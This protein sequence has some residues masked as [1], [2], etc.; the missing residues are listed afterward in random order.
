MK[1]AITGASGFAGQ[2]ITRR[3]LAEGHTVRALVR[4]P[5]A[6]S[7]AGAEAR[8][9]DL[10][11]PRSIATAAHECDVLV[12]AAAETHPGSAAAALGWRN[13]AGTENAINAAR[14]AGIER[15]VHVSCTDATLVAAPRNHWKEDHVPLQPLVGE[16][17]RSKQRAEEVVIGGG[18]IAGAD[19][20]IDIVILRPGM[21]WGAGDER[22]RLPR[23]CGEAIATGS[24]SLCGDGTNLVATTHVDNLAEAVHRALVVESAAGGTFHVLDGELALAQ[25]FFGD[26]AE[27][28]S[29]AKPTRPRL[30]FRGAYAAARL[31]ARASVSRTS[32]PTRSS[33]VAKARTS[34]WKPPGRS[35]TTGRPCPCTKVSPGSGPGPRR[36]AARCT[37][38]ASSVAPP[39][40]RASPRRSTPPS[41]PERWIHGSTPRRLS[42]SC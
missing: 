6:F 38:R 1:I 34:A 35:S 14:H 17:A 27:A 11:D 10:A 9:A 36:W 42:T 32:P 22:S 21:L 5:A 37:S 13:V 28:L 31:R 33:G 24:L 40:R 39:T 12:H 3:L 16:L 29:L 20:S 41:A 26:L 2:A 7:L 30:G 19:G 4:R 25:D 8:A 15:F 18:G 23:L